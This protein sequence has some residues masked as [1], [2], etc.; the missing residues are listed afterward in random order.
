MAHNYPFPTYR[1]TLAHLQQTTF[2]NIVTKAEIAQ[3]KQFFLLT[4]CFQLFF[5]I[6]I[7]VFRDFHVLSRCFQGRLLQICLYGKGLTK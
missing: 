6:Y 2:E 1:R 7:F 4:K 5:S 3:N